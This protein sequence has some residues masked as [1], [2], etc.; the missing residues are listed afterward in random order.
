MAPGP[1][2]TLIT[3]VPAP[4]GS[5]HLTLLD[6]TGRAA[7]GWPVKLAGATSCGLLFP[8]EDGSVRILCTPADLNQELN[9]GVRGFAF[10]SRGKRMPGWPIEIYGY[11]VDG[12]M[13]GDDVTLLVS[14]SLTDM[15]EEGRPSHTVGLVTIGPDGSI[16]EGVQEPRLEDWPGEHWA[17]GP[18]GIAYGSSVVSGL[19]ER[20]AEVSSLI[21][22]DLSGVPAGWPVTFPGLA[23][24]P[25]FGSDGR[26]FMTVGSM[27]RRE[28]RGLAVDPETRSVS[29]S[30][31]PLATSK[32]EF[33]DTGGCSL[34]NP[35]APLVAPDGTAFI[36]SW[37]NHEIFA[38]DPSLDPVPGWLHIPYT[39]FTRRDPRYVREDAY[40]PS[41]SLPAVGPDST[42]Y[43]SQ[44]ARD[45]TVGGSLA[46]VGSDRRLPRGWPVELRRPGAEFWSVI[47]GSNGTAYALAIE[48]ESS[49]SSSGTILAIAPDST[50]LYATT[51][52]EP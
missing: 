45:A 49:D 30:A 22:M 33:G 18:D 8:V 12:R 46:T 2:G 16:V 32:A 24:G 4:D 39:P 34:G 40:C 1:D 5:V 43:T 19:D 50:V 9:Q 6:S 28:S 37:P 13:V 27:I 44:E 35:Q 3:S 51:V 17:V 26:I 41:L 7:A 47:V 15:V 23:S 52:I 20:S 48:L 10:D 29:A 25:A 21:A 36:L 11:H 42:L 31:A 14:R 38:L